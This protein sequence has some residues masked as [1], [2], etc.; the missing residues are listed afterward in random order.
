M[1]RKVSFF[2]IQGIIIIAF[3]F[4]GFRAGE[5][6]GQIVVDNPDHP[7][8]KNAG[9]TVH[10][11]EVYRIRDDGEKIIFR[12]PGDFSLAGDG[13]L[14]FFDYP[15]LYKY[16]KNGRFVFKALKSGVGPG[17]F[18]IWSS[19]FLTADRI[20]VHAWR[21]SKLMDYD[22]NGRYL[23]EIKTDN[24]PGPFSRLWS[25]DG[26]IYGLR[27]EIRY[28]DSIR[29]EGFIT[30]PYVLYEIS[31][32]F[33][34]QKRLCEFPVQHYIKQASWWRRTMIA[35]AAFDHYLFVVHTAEYKIV[36][37]DLRAARIERIFKRDY[38]RR[39]SHDKVTEEDPYNP[40]A[41]SLAPPPE[42]YVFDVFGIKVFKN[43]LWVLT[44]MLKSGESQGLI[45]VFDM[46][47]NYLD[48]FYL[49]FPNRQT[50]DIIDSLIS[51]DGFIF[52]PEQAEDGLV[53]IAKYR[54]KDK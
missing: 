14:I 17:E 37:F 44:S 28:S 7:A 22:L 53:S 29:K 18:H 10:L 3:F 8:A 46:E 19:Y 36:K 47:G 6:A 2:H 25:I 54:I 35:G 5:P 33:Q 32:D 41:K 13:S 38:R 26:R 23:R 15:N 51:D 42:E 16:D 27:D 49:R 12:N 21:P 30:S 34:E 39:K 52:V 31:E 50:Q 11:E 20:R 43:S 40:R 4:A 9:R 24:V 1:R 48:N 45:D